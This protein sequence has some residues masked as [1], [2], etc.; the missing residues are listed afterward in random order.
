ME[1]LTLNIDP[2]RRRSGQ[3]DS[4]ACCC[5][6]SDCALLKKNCTVLETVE[7]DVQTAAHLGQVRNA[8]LKPH[9]SPG[10]VLWVVVCPAICPTSPH[11]VACQLGTYMEACPDFSIPEGH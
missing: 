1:G 6:R 3:S 8:Q 5:G 7:K 4:I 10:R 11:L 2:N 9:S